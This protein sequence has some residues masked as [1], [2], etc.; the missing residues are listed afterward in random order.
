M[1]KTVEVRTPSRAWSASICLCVLPTSLT[2][3][4]PVDGIRPLITNGSRD[5]PHG[6]TGWPKPAV[7]LGGREITAYSRLQWYSDD[8][9]VELG[10]FL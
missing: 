10:V 9:Y 7:E 5:R 1:R 2:E 4:P 8:S 3:N 6:S